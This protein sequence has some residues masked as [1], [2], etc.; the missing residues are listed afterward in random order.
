MA[1]TLMSKKPGRKKGLSMVITTLL[2]VLLSIVAVGV[3][4]VS[5]RS[6]IAGRAESNEACFGNYDKI[7]VNERYTCYEEISGGYSLRFAITRGDVD[8]DSVIVSITSVSGSKTYEITN[9]GSTG[10]LSL[11]SGGVTVLP[12]RNAQ[13]SY[14]A[15]GFS[16]IIDSIEIVPVISGNKCGISDAVAEI[17]NCNILAS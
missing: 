11:Y 10:G 9:T 5:F 2:L 14:V 16:E 6:L 4:W 15:S 13:L 1:G 8:A 7:T 12:E 17:V 3:V